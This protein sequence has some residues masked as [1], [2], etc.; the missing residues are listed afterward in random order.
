MLHIGMGRNSLKKNKPIHI[1][2]LHK[3]SIAAGICFFHPGNFALIR[4]LHSECILGSLTSDS[5]NSVVYIL[6]LSWDVKQIKRIKSACLS[7]DLWALVGT[8]CYGG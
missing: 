6:G 2:M 5:T 8:S 1:R 3:T 7:A 4:T